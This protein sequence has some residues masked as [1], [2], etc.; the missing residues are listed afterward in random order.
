MGLDWYHNGVLVRASQDQRISINSRLLY[1]YPMKSNLTL[2]PAE[3]EDNGEYY[4]EAIFSDSYSK[5]SRPYTLHL[6]G[7]GLER[8]IIVV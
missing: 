4:C 6:T 2:F 3:N 1:N 8:I 7:K 5:A